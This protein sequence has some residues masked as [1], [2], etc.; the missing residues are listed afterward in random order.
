MS[1]KET[2]IV[3]QPGGNSQSG[4]LDQMSRWNKK[5]QFRGVGPILL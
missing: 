3:L 1:A 5:Q 2:V 4:A